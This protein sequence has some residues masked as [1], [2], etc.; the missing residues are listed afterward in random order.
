MFVASHKEYQ[1]KVEKICLIRIQLLAIK[2]SEA[3]LRKDLPFV[4][5]IDDLNFVGAHNL[6]RYINLFASKV[7]I[8]EHPG[9]S[10]RLSSHLGGGKR[11]G[12]IYTSIKRKA[13]TRLA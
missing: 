10:E 5:V 11:V 3:Q 13:W 1:A 2:A 6:A 12:E 8:S 7:T 9:I 4:R